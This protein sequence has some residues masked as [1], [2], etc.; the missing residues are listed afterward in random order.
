MIFQTSSGCGSETRSRVLKQL[1]AMEPKRQKDADTL[2]FTRASNFF[3]RAH[4]RR[5]HVQYFCSRRKQNYSLAHLEEQ[6][7]ATQAQ[8]RT[9]MLSASGRG[10]WI[11]YSPHSWYQM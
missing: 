11:V 7:L 4:E 1:V 5:N 10:R 3:R 9:S 8:V 6:N 2:G